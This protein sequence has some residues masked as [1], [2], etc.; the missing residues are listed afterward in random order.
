MQIK[1]AT[2]VTPAIRDTRAIALVKRVCVIVAS[3]YLVIGMIALYRAL[4]QVHSLEI[5]SPHVLQHGSSAT[6]TVVSYGRVPL[7]LQLELVQED[8][9]E[10]IAFQRVPTNEWSLLDSRTREWSQTVVITD[11]LLARFNDGQATIRVTAIGRQQLG[12]FPQPV[13]RAQ[14]IALQRD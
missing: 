1:E 12:H 14:F 13:I 4:V 6:A 11:E 5:Q 10:I 7:T 8:H 3:V 9:A 2:F